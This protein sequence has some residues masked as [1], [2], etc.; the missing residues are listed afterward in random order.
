MPTVDFDPGRRF[1]PDSLIKESKNSGYL[2]AQLAFHRDSASAIAGARKSRGTVSKPAGTSVTARV[3]KGRAS[4]D[5]AAIIA[6][7]CSQPLKAGVHVRPDY[8]DWWGA[9]GT[10]SR[11]ALGRG[12]IL[13]GLYEVDSGDLA[14]G[15]FAGC[16][17]NRSS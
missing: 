13:P 2:I 11:R 8:G 1:R 14:N 10:S 5:Q 6:T 4:A 17:L 16:V 12:A 9:D 15:V 3:G 7:C